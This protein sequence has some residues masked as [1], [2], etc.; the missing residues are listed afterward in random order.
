MVEI[1]NLKVKEREGL[2]PVF[3]AS[4]RQCENN[5]QASCLPRHSAQLLVCPP[6]NPQKVRPDMGS[7]SS[8]LDAGN[9]SGAGPQSDQ[10]SSPGKAIGSWQVGWNPWR[11]PRVFAL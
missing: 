5:I 9:A 6:G 7:F 8:S 1:Q 10:G 4:H 3:M 2:A 11:I